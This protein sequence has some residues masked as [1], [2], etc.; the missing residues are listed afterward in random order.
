MSRK[1]ARRL[2]SETVSLTLDLE[3]GQHRVDFSM[4]Y[5]GR[6]TLREIVFVGRGKI[7]QGLDML[8]HEISIKASRAIQ[9]RDPDTG[10]LVK[11]MD[12]LPLPAPPKKNPSI[13]AVEQHL[14]MRA[15]D[16]E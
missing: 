13:L 11:D 10:E 1:A 12:E 15:D 4:A 8:L 9:R 7:G 3:N 14:G 5:D 16:G 6:G 2:Q